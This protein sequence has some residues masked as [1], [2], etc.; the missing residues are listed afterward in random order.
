MMTVQEYEKIVLR[1]L[2]TD[3]LPPS[4][5]H[6]AIN[7]PEKISCKFTGAGYF[8]DLSHEDVPEGR[9]V[10]SKPEVIGR[11]QEREVGFVAFIDKGLITL[12]CHD[13]DG[14]GIPE[15]IRYGLVEIST[16]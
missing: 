3:T 6:A 16:I 9:I 14:H 4:V 11:F 5:L 8:L 13:Y 2:C 7:T 1:L 15:N 10:C 12:E